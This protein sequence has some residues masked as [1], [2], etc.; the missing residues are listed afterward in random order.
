MT[1]TIK[2][3]KRGYVLIRDGGKYS[4]HAHIKKECTCKFVIDCIKK[5]KM[6]R[7]KYL[8]GSVKRLLTE[9][10][11]NEMIVKEKPKYINRRYVG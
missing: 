8:K 2:Q 1:F 7:S 6:P 10:E 5:R 4:Q 11:F 9:K 3:T